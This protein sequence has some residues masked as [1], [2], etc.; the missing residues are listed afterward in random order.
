MI[1]DIHSEMVI[2]KHHALAAEV[3]MGSITRGQRTT[4]VDI[5][6]VADQK[7]NGGLLAR[8]DAVGAVS[9]FQFPF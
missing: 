7:P 5:H 2:Q 8:G 1:T 4:T 9:H 3:K 6:A